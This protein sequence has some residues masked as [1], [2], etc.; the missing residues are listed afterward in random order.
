MPLVWL[1]ACAT[2]HVGWVFGSGDAAISLAA[3]DGTGLAGSGTTS[4]TDGPEGSDET[5]TFATL[6]DNSGSVEVRV[7]VN[8]SSTSGVEAC[9]V[10]T[11]S[12]SAAF[13]VEL[14]D[15]GSVP[16][17]DT[18]YASIYVNSDTGGDADDLGEWTAEIDSVTSGRM[19][20]EV[21]DWRTWDAADPCYHLGRTLVDTSW[22]FDADDRDEIRH[23]SYR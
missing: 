20:F 8:L 6:D 19:H 1:L 16:T 7:E 23:G 10:T 12:F 9:E 11:V 21:T 2:E 15:A 3:P 13:H 22:S 17:P 18:L 5:G 14:L 4:D